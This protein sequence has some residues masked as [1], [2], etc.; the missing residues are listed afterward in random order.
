MYNI[1]LKKVIKSND[2][3]DLSKNLKAMDEF[4]KQSSESD[5]FYEE[6][7]SDIRRCVPEQNGAFHIWTGD[8]WATAYILYQWIIPFF[9][10]WNKKRL[11]VISNYLEQ[12]YIPA[13]GKIICPEMVRELLDFIELKYGF[14]SKLARNP[15]DIFIVNN[16]TKSYNSFY[17][18]SF[19][20]YG[21]VHDLIFLSSMRDT[22]Q[23]TP[24]FVFLHELGHLIHTRLIK[25]GFTVPVSFD[26]LTSQVRMFKDI[27]NDETLAELFCESFAL[28]AF[29]RTPYEKYVML[30]GV[31]QSDRDII[32]FYFFVFMHTL[33]QNPDGTLP[34]QDILSLFSRGTYG[35]D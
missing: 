34:W 32:S 7:Y 24:E 21:D 26:F 12:K 15:I 33:E 8:E 19:D 16:T 6:L 35:S 31:K 4:I 13:Q 25:K 1:L 30:D 29:N 28:A 22:Q 5:I 9:N 11:V 27:E 18:F 14:L 20:L 2:M 3:L 17:N 23:V 10:Q